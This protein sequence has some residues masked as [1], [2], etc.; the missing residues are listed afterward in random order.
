MPLATAAPTRKARRLPAKSWMTDPE[1]C[2]MLQVQ[3]DD[4]GA[5]AELVKRYW[6][7]VF[8][9]FFRKLHQSDGHLLVRFYIQKPYELAK[10]RLP[11]V[12][13]ML[14]I[15]LGELAMRLRIPIRGKPLQDLAGAAVKALP[16]VHLRQGQRRHGRIERP[17]S[18]AVKVTC[19][20]RWCPGARPRRR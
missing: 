17:R 12:L 20:R 13:L 16:R 14:P 3:R 4:A 6:P 19:K 9:Q 11:K 18:T 8:G 15:Q 5:F 10:Y 2:L 7:V 1:V